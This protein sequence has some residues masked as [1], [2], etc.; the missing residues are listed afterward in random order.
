MLPARNWEGLVPAMRCLPCGGPRRGRQS[1]YGRLSHSSTRQE[2]AVEM[3]FPMWLMPVHSFIA[4]R[5]L[6]AHEDVRDC[7]SPAHAV[8]AA[9][10]HVEAAIEERRHARLAWRCA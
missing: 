1:S 4:L 9:H 5:R 2:T 3:L 6:E 7:L 8:R 10:A